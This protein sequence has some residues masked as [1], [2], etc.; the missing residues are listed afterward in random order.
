MSF[1]YLC[2]HC[3]QGHIRPIQFSYDEAVLTCDNEDCDS[4]LDVSPWSCIVNRNISQVYL[5]A[6][7]QR[8]IQHWSRSSSSSSGIQS[9]VRSPGFSPARSFDS[10][11]DREVENLLQRYINNRPKTAAKNPVSC[12]KPSDDKRTSELNNFSSFFELL[13]SLD[14]ESTD[15]QSSKECIPVTAPSV[16]EDKKLDP[17]ISE[18][19]SWMKGFESPMTSNK[20]DPSPNVDAKDTESAATKDSLNN[21]LY[22]PSRSSAF[23]Q[24]SP[25]NDSG[26]SSS[27]C[28]LVDGDA[29]I[30]ERNPER[31][32]AAVEKASDPAKN[33]LLSFNEANFLSPATSIVSDDSGYDDPASKINSMLLLPSAI[34]NLGKKVTCEKQNELP[35]LRG[36]GLENSGSSVPATNIPPTS[37]SPRLF[38]QPSVVMNDEDSSNAKPDEKRCSRSDAE[39]NDVKPSATT[40]GTLCNSS[41]FEDSISA[42]K[43]KSLSSSESSA[44]TNSNTAGALQE[45]TSNSDSSLQTKASE[46]CQVKPPP[47]KKSGRPRGRPPKDANPVHPKR[48]SKRRRV[49]AKREESA[50]GS[51]SLSKGLASV[52]QS[53]SFYVRKDEARHHNH[54]NITTLSFRNRLNG[55]FVEDPW[56]VPELYLEELS[57]EI[58]VQGRRDTPSS[59]KESKTSIPNNEETPKGDSS[60][61]PED[62]KKNAVRLESKKTGASSSVTD[63]LD[64]ECLNPSTCNVG[65]SSPKGSESCS[66]DGY[67]RLERENSDSESDNSNSGDSSSESC[68]TRDSEIDSVVKVLVP[69]SD[70]SASNTEDSSSLQRLKCSHTEENSEVYDR[71]SSPSEKGLEKHLKKDETGKQTLKSCDGALTSCIPSRSDLIDNSHIVE[72]KVEENV[73]ISSGQMKDNSCIDK[74]KAEENIKGDLPSSQMIGER[75][76]SNNKRPEINT[77]TSTSVGDS[78]LSGDE[79]KI[80]VRDKSMELLDLPLSESL[81]D[82]DTVHCSE[83]SPTKGTEHGC[84]SHLDTSFELNLSNLHETDNLMLDFASSSSPNIRSWMRHE[85]SKPVMVKKEKID[86]DVPERRLSR[87]EERKIRGQASDY[88]N[89]LLESLDFQEEFFQCPT[90]ENPSSTFGEHLSSSLF[91]GE[92]ACSSTSTS[93]ARA[94]TCGSSAS[95]VCASVPDQSSVSSTVTT[96]NSPTN[97]PVLNVSC[98]IKST[99][100][101]VPQSGMHTTTSKGRIPSAEAASTTSVTQSLHQ[102]IPSIQDISSLSPSP[103]G[104]IEDKISSDI[105]LNREKDV[106]SNPMKEK[107][108]SGVNLSAK[109]LRVGQNSTDA[110]RNQDGCEKDGVLRDNLLRIKQEPTSTLYADT[111]GTSGNSCNSKA[112]TPANM[113]DTPF[114]SI[115]SDDEIQIIMPNEKSITEKSRST[116]PIGQNED[117]PELRGDS[118]VGILAP[119]SYTSEPPCLLPLG[120]SKEA[121]HKEVVKDKKL[122]DRNV[123]RELGTEDRC[124]FYNK[125]GVG[126]DLSGIDNYNLMCGILDNSVVHDSSCFS[127]N[128]KGFVEFDENCWSEKPPENINFYFGSKKT[129]FK[130]CEDLKVNCNT[131]SKTPLE[132]LDKITLNEKHLGSPDR[133]SMPFTFEVGSKFGCTKSSPQHKLLMSPTAEDSGIEKVLDAKNLSFLCYDSSSETCSSSSSDEDENYDSETSM[134]DRLFSSSTKK[135]ALSI[136]KPRF[137]H[138]NVDLNTSFYDGSGEESETDREAFSRKRRMLDRDVLRMDSA[139]SDSRLFKK[140]QMRF[141]RKLDSTLN[142]ESPSELEQESWAKMASSPCILAEPVKKR[143]ALSQPKLPVGTHTKFMS[144]PLHKPFI[145]SSEKLFSAPKIPKELC[146]STVPANNILNQK[147]ICSKSNLSK[148]ALGNANLL[149]YPIQK[150]T[151]P[152]NTSIEKPSF[153]HSIPTSSSSLPSSS[154][155]SS[156]SLSSTNINCIASSSTTSLKS[157]SFIDC[158]MP[159]VTNSNVIIPPALR[160]SYAPI[161]DGTRSVFKDVGSSNKV[162]NMQEKLIVIKNETPNGPVMKVLRVNV[163]P[164]ST[165]KSQNGSVVSG[166]GT[167]QPS[168]S[169]MP[170]LN[171]ASNGGDSSE[172]ERTP[173]ASNVSDS[174]ERERTPK[175]SSEKTKKE[176]LTKVRI[177]GSS[178]R[179]RTPKDS[180]SEETKKDLL[181]KIKIGAN[182]KF[183]V[184]PTFAMMKAISEMRKTKDQESLSEETEV[185]CVELPDGIPI[186]HPFQIPSERSLKHL[187]QENNNKKVSTANKK[188]RKRRKKYIL[189]RIQNLVKEKVQETV[190]RSKDEIPEMVAVFIGGK[191]SVYRRDVDRRSAQ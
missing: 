40:S 90:T 140:P 155:S 143:V 191:L 154:S 93:V 86:T 51:A 41:Q 20:K 104:L 94:S 67:D 133:S 61:L 46:L 177:G 150:H 24:V 120:T 33:C 28:S 139:D 161:E 147:H 106:I 7:N 49:I 35:E 39:Q 10:A 69:Y 87:S 167:Q 16:C 36:S 92:T 18:L 176:V 11:T 72:V 23:S 127:P 42:S 157:S 158:Q 184:R 108:P 6:S 84:D 29:A 164:N 15:Q 146:T 181:T 57:I 101:A 76:S 82:I 138:S 79:S 70:S 71:E 174:S 130:L 78:K 56:S 75:E 65:Q 151:M 121:S 25:K 114:I 129:N 91:F 116:K 74:T 149:H 98:S 37:A 9:D 50:P 172:R 145:Q 3:G 102:A 103:S 55:S 134:S 105:V 89:T 169:Q 178:E 173:K 156:S 123:N 117:I 26:Q 27:S 32:I 14:L 5:P 95:S 73:D 113:L 166:S 141:K 137:S 58:V 68:A 99:S 63:T 189:Q 187:Y 1:E 96:V 48:V 19:E 170:K 30:T 54:H 81:L 165:V 13:D 109:N 107:V 126:K 182:G 110:L 142:L 148:D 62:S 45:P 186:S 162:S 47:V 163:I 171:V 144:P 31:S 2:Q 44:K 159:S 188:R 179:E 115:D 111:D 128:A 17:V 66:K 100:G 97:V 77:L 190:T 135:F 83:L 53:P 80:H 38:T 88:F 52:L 125:T 8:H 12:P 136:G 124:S 132:Q 60:R 175:D 85:E 122:E 131:L 119:S 34:P 118:K 185:D 153:C 152:S 180:G 183:Y 43:T 64:G 21:R 4:H 22:I 168:T 112:S 59:Q 160:S